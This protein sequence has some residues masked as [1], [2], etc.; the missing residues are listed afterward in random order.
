MFRT[1]SYKLFLSRVNPWKPIPLYSRIHVLSGIFTW[2]SV[3]KRN[4]LKR[5]QPFGRSVCA[6]VQTHMEAWGRCCADWLWLSSTDLQLSCSHM[7]VR[8]L[9]LGPQAFQQGL[10]LLSHFLRPLSCLKEK[11]NVTVTMLRSTINYL[12]YLCHVQL[13]TIVSSMITSL[14]LLYKEGTTALWWLVHRGSLYCQIREVALMFLLP[15]PPFMCL[16]YVQMITCMKKVQKCLTCHRRDGRVSEAHKHLN[17]FAA[18]EWYAECPW[19]R[20][21]F[22]DEISAPP[23]LL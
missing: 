17:T 15:P 19:H 4:L 23:L 9:S 2:F 11:I 12:G 8:N 21:S 18:A 10:Y 16:V 13:K 7:G 14:V 5:N 6:C 22:H 20:A 1:G 3:L